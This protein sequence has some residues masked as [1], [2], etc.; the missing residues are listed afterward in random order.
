MANSRPRAGNLQGKPEKSHVKK[1]VHVQRLMG[2]LKRKIQK[3]AWDKLDIRKSD[4][5]WQ[6]KTEFM[7]L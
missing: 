5:N 6:I 4:N 2:S 1:Q 3:L 7:S